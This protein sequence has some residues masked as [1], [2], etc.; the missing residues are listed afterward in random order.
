MRVGAH[1]AANTW[2]EAFG[3]VSEIDQVHAMP[4][5]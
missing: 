3:F 2:P 4:L 1:E 5:R